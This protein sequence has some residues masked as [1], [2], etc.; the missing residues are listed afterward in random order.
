MVVMPLVVVPLSISHAFFKGSTSNTASQSISA[1]A[2][3]LCAGLTSGG[4]CTGSAYGPITPATI[5]A[6]PITKIE[7]SVIGGTTVALG[8][9]TG[10]AVG[11]VV[12]GTNIGSSGINWIASIASPNVTL[13]LGGSTSS[14]AS[15]ITFSTCTGFAQ[16]LSLNNMGTAAINQI[17]VTDTPTGALGTI[18]LQS[19]NT[20]GAGTTAL[21]WST[22]AN[23]GLCVGEINT[24]VT[25]TGTT[26]GSATN[27]SL[28]IAAAGS[29]RL[30][31]LSSLVTETLTVS[32]SVT[33]ANL[34][35]QS[36]NG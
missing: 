35:T 4:A 7:S 22:E 11:M 15:V 24:I 31:A 10:L 17:N 9:V 36:T 18:A 1:G 34:A 29:T 21:A 16:F 2:W 30:R 8:D 25:V 20:G 13:G 23:G 3:K 26:P 27:Y 32:A 19:C 33:K 14:L 6:A 5:C 12:S 28:A